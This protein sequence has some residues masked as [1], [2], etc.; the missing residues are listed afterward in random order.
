MVRYAM[1]I[2]KHNLLFIHR[3]SYNTDVKEQMRGGITKRK[4][5][6][7][8]QYMHRTFIKSGIC[9][10]CKLKKKTQWSNISG[11][12]L[13]QRSDWKELCASCHYKT[14]LIIHQAS[15]ARRFR[16]LQEIKKELVGTSIKWDSMREVEARLKTYLWYNTENP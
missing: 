11:K 8:H 3:F 15:R 9:D 2:V 6:A 7:V 4:Y 14:D 16:L 5:D 13:R 12:Y 1:A 10:N